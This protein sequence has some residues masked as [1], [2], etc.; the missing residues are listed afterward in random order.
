MPAQFTQSHWP[1]VSGMDQRTILPTRGS[2]IKSSGRRTREEGFKGHASVN[3]HSCSSSIKRLAGT[4][5]ALGS[6]NFPL[7]SKL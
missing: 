1:C 6:L 5:A 2:Y 4:Q 3:V 7:I